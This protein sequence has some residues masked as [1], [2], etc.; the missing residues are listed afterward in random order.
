MTRGLPQ[1]PGVAIPWQWREPRSSADVDP[2]EPLELDE[3]TG[4]ISV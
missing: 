1:A 3:S 4:G 2:S